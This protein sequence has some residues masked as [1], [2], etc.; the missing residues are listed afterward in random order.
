M[1]DNDLPALKYFMEDLFK[2]EA[3]SNPPLMP[4][5]ILCLA[6]QLSR[7]LLA[8]NISK[9]QESTWQEGHYLPSIVET[10]SPVVFGKS[11]IPY[12]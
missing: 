10:W 12:D 2:V 7:W 11:I 9:F 8:G 1:Y 4:F 6:I 5:V 3:S